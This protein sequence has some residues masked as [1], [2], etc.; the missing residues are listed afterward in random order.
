V[1]QYFRDI[2]ADKKEKTEGDE[3]WPPGNT[4]QKQ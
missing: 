3:Q 2:K 4:D 1:P